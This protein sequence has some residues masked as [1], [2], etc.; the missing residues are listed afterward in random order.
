[1]TNFT[2]TAR[3]LQAPLRMSFRKKNQ[4]ART[5]TP[6]G[7]RIHRKVDLRCREECYTVCVAEVRVSRTHRHP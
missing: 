5:G 6:R 3:Q 2:G 7:Y 4:M 1:M